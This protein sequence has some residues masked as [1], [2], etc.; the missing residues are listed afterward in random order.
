[1]LFGIGPRDPLTFA[2]AAAVAL[3]SALLASWLPA[4]RAARVEPMVVLRQE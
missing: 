1:M 3:V 4:R 2:A